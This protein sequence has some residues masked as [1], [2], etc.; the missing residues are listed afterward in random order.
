M[1]AD[2]QPISLAAYVGKFLVL[3]RAGGAVLAELTSGTASANGRIDMEPQG[4][5][6]MRVTL[7]AAF[8]ATLS[9]T[10]AYQAH[11]IPTADATVV[12]YLASGPLVVI[13]R[14]G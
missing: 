7:S 8:T 13:K 10:G 14:G 11:L 5:G 1:D 4:T 3:S 2:N 12:E 9:R 6:T